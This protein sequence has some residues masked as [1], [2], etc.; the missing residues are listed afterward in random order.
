MTTHHIYPKVRC[1]SHK[2]MNCPSNKLRLWRD[3]HSA[4]HNIFFNHSFDEIVYDMHRYWYKHRETPQWK[5]L[6]KNLPLLEVVRLIE[7][8]IAIKASLKGKY[9]G[10]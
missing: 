2:K 1:S 5:L 7:R 9:R 4:F 3:K 10:K 8:T 6:F